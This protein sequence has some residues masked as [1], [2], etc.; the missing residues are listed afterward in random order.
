[1]ANMPVQMS[2]THFC[3]CSGW[4]Y[5]RF[6]ILD[7]S[8]SKR[9]ILHHCDIHLKRLA[10]FDTPFCSEQNKYVDNVSVRC[11]PTKRA[12]SERT[13]INFHDN[14]GPMKIF[15]VLTYKYKQ[16]NVRVHCGPVSSCFSLLLVV[17]FFK[18]RNAVLTGLNPTTQDMMGPWINPLRKKKLHLD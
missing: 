2:S 12:V 10:Y 6:S 18:K 4:E 11:F 5:W 7:T 3:I 13:I 14:V 1:M 15:N 8:Y 16:L 9:P 17:S